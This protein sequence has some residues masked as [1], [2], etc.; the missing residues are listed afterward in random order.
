MPVEMRWVG[1]SGSG[2][3]I[4]TINYTTKVSRTVRRSEPEDKDDRF[5]NTSLI[6]LFQSSWAIA[7]S[8]S[9]H[10]RSKS[11]NVLGCISYR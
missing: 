2:S 6:M 4:T 1:F 7:Y 11:F 5:K 3:H 8:Y 9:E 10:E